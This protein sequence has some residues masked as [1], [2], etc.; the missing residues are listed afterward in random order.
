MVVKKVLVV[1]SLGLIICLLKMV[2]QVVKSFCCFNSKCWC[3]VGDQMRQCSIADA[4]GGGE[5]KRREDQN[6]VEKKV[7]SQINTCFYIFLLFFFQWKCSRQ[8]V[9]VSQPCLHNKPYIREAE[10]QPGKYDNLLVMMMLMLMVMVIMSDYKR[11]TNQV[12]ITMLLMMMF[13]GG[14]LDTIPP[15]W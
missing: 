10:H 7:F 8:S 4:G 15:F 5:V 3:L 2:R 1:T 14:I 9:E 12:A 13:P 6:S 11:K